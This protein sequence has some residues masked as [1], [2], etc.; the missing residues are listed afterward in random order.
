[1]PYGRES[2]Y[3]GQEAQD[4]EI[5]QQNMP[6]AS[7]EEKSQAFQQYRQEKASSQ[8]GMFDIYQFLESIGIGTNQNLP[9]EVQGRM[10]MGR[11]PQQI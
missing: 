6:N 3:T 4:W 8:D 11:Q 5:L 7:E 1:M 9:P 10:Q 2:E